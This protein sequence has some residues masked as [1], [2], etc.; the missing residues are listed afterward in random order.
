MSVSPISGLPFSSQLLAHPGCCCEFAQ[1]DCA[2]SSRASL[3]SRDNAILNISEKKFLAKQLSTKQS[4][5]AYVRRVVIGWHAS[6][7]AADWPPRGCGGRRG[8][9]RFGD[10]GTSVPTP[11]PPFPFRISLSFFHIYENLKSQARNFSQTPKYTRRPNSTPTYRSLSPGRR[12]MK[13]TE[14]E[15]R[16][17]VKPPDEGRFPTLSAEAA[18]P[19]S[20]FILIRSLK[21]KD[22]DTLTVVHYKQ[23]FFLTT[24]MIR[25]FT[26][27]YSRPTNTKFS[28]HKPNAHNNNAHNKANSQTHFCTSNRSRRK[29][30]HVFSRPGKCL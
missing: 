15:C 4:E 22:T 26:A 17:K 19:T 5:V 27:H 2:S 8:A 16:F 1:C 20:F 13:H 28:K 12:R 18:N 23:F 3:F 24:P 10:N 6:Q 25:S 30:R 21:S 9:L 29:C 11:S 14:R 7:P